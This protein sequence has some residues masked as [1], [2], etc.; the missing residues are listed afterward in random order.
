MSGGGPSYGYWSGGGTGSFSRSLTMSTYG[1]SFGG[2][3][4]DALAAGRPDGPD[5][6]GQGLGAAGLILGIFG[7]VNSAIGTFYEARSAKNAFK[8]QA[9]T[10]EFEQTQANANARLAEQDA[11]A[12]I[13]AGHDE[14]ARMTLAAGQEKAS[15]T[16][17]EAARGVVSGVGSAA[18]VQA[19]R[20]LMK[21]I[22][23]MTINA[24]AT[25]AA[26][27]MRIRGANMSGRAGLLGASAENA[28]ASGRL[29]RPGAAAGASLLSSAGPVASSAAR[30]YARGY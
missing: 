29:L 4:Q 10:L 28:R 8:A 17:R 26:G 11:Q 16:V 22:D 12:E 7:A 6:T 23:S 25:R 30:Y 1:P 19:T 9:L 15:A 5:T 27:A 2:A 13:Q 18:E 21:Q 14:L 24:N 20:E 3:G